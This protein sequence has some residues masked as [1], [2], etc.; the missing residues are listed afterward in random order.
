MT[1]SS[2]GG[3]GKF[4]CGRTNLEGGFIK[5]N[6]GYSRFE[7]K[8]LCGAP[9]TSPSLSNETA[10]NNCIWETIW[11]SIQVGNLIKDCPIE[12]EYCGFFGEIAKQALTVIYQILNNKVRV[13]PK[14]EHSWMSKSKRE[15]ALEMV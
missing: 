15:V 14:T 4:W 9:S 6:K 11:L 2:R 8:C 5:E 13:L 7:M 1:G 12:T 10:S 3:Q